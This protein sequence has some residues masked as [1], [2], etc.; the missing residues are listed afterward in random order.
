MRG[1]S[2]YGW[3][4]DYRL[5]N[6]PTA[7]CFPESGYR[8][9]ILA[10]HLAHDIGLHSWASPCNMGDRPGLMVLEDLELA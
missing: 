10:Q 1:G 8:M 2:L 5:S 4:P 9:A 3:V 7:R 6:H